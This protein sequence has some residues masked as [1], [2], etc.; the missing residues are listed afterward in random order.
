MNNSLPT[1]ISIVALISSNGALSD[2]N[3]SYGRCNTQDSPK[4]VIWACTKLMMEP[5]FSNSERCMLTFRRALAYMRKDNTCG[6]HGALSDL[7]KVIKKK[8]PVIKEAHYKRAIVYQR[9]FKKDPSYYDEKTLL[10]AKKDLQIYSNLEHSMDANQLI[11]SMLSEINNDL[12]KIQ[13]PQFAYEDTSD[14]KNDFTHW[15]TS[16]IKK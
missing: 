9:L 7:D 2:E 10:D 6:L 5:I 14:E 16:R 3:N 4:K 11:A 12:I 1:I 15:L 13:N 8:C